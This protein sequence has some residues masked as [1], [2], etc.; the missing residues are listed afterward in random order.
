MRHSVLGQ[1]SRG[2][3]GSMQ[4]I[5][6]SQSRGYATG[7]RGPFYWHSTSKR[8]AGDEDA[9][10]RA[11]TPSNDPG[12][13]DRTARR[14]FPVAADVAQGKTLLRLNNG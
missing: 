6:E 1:V 7:I 5:G 10:E 2:S 8:A 3:I 4:F 14:F 13:I 12:K 11:T 9:R